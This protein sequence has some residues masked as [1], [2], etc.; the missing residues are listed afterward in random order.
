MVLAIEN[1]LV[2]IRDLYGFRLLVMKR[3]SHGVVVFAF[4]NYVLDLMKTTYKRVVYFG[5]VNL[6]VKIIFE[7]LVRM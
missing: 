2:A 4:K 3:K 6:D 5:V 7:R 1:Q